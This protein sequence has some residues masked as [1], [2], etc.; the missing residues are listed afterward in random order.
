MNSVLPLLVAGRRA[1]PI[2][3]LT[4]PSSTGDDAYSI[5]IWLLEHWPP[6]NEFDVELTGVAIDTHV[7]EL[8]RGGVFGDHALMYVDST[9]R[10]RYLKAL[11][12]GQYQIRPRPS[13]ATR[14]ASRSP[15][16]ANR[17]K[18]SACATLT[19]SSAATR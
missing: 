1:A 5:A 15:T 12:A 13:C 7:V 14:S 18:C 10:A 17:A 19:S 6:I 2:R 16:S 4:L 9:L 11:G 8:A 3:L